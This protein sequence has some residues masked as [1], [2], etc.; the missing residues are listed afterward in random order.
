MIW[1]TWISRWEAALAACAKL[2][3]DSRRLKIEAPASEAEVAAVERELGVALPFSF[4]ETLVLPHF[5]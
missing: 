5:W 4:R 3:G 2:G 1:E